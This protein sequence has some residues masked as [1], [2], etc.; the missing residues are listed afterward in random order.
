MRRNKNHLSQLGQL[1]LFVQPFHHPT[2]HP[3]DQPLDLLLPSLVFGI[4]EIQ[5]R[6]QKKE[7]DALLWPWSRVHA[8]RLVKRIMDAAGI[9]D[10][11]HK[12]PKSL[13]E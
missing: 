7:L 10:G 3:L 12:A 9:V 8:W 1:F 2:L 11:P 6:G 13:S 5:K 4:R